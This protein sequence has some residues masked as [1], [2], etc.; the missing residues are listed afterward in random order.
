MVRRL[1]AEMR[2][3]FWEADF[4]ALDVTKHEHYLIGR[5]LEYGRMPEVR[6]AI[7]TYGLNRIHRFLRRVGHP[8]LSARTLSFWRAVLHAETE[9]WASPPAWRKS[10]VAHWPG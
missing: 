8:E 6:W 10:S 2:W 3:L 7:D 1:P 4:D 9:K 5:V